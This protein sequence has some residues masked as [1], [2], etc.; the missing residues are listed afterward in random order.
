M[1]SPVCMKILTQQY[2]KNSRY[3]GTEINSGDSTVLE[4]DAKRADVDGAN[5]YQSNN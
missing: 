1:D 5:E 4:N 2:S 3:D